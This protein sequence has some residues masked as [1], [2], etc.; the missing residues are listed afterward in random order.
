MLLEPKPSNSSNQRQQE[1]SELAL[2][3]IMEGSN[4]P[5]RGTDK[6]FRCSKTVIM[7]KHPVVLAQMLL[8]SL[9]VLKAFMVIMEETPLHSLLSNNS[10]A[11]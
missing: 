3:E 6:S 8:H 11:P 7:D 1:D 10:V 9:R 5:N 2:L 4:D